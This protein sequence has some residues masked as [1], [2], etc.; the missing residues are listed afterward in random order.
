MKDPRTLE[1]MFY[2]ANRY[3]LAEEVTLDS[4]EQK[5]SGHTD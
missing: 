3:T 1:K 5:E 4:R 2:I